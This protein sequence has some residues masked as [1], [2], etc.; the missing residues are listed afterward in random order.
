M[1]G[2]SSVQKPEKIW[3]L[4]AAGSGEMPAHR[5]GPPRILKHRVTT[6]GRGWPLCGVAT[7]GGFFAPLPIRAADAQ[8]RG[9]TES[10]ESEQRSDHGAFSEN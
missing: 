8:S 3:R 5:L 10:Q 4:A 6:L 1:F 2:K 9:E 7:E